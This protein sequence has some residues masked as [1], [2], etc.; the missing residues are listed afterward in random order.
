M[1]VISRRVVAS[2]VRTAS[3]TWAVITSLLAPSNGDGRKELDSIAGVV[4]SLI[5]E[6]SPANDP[7]VVWGN[8]PRVRVYCL[9]GEDAITEDGKSEDA[10]AKSPT[11]GDWAMSLPCP[12]EEL[13]W[14]SK[15]LAKHSTRI[16]ARKLG[17]AVPDDESASKSANTTTEIDHE[18]FFRP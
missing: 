16:T 12:E 4:C 8:G 9:F 1:S 13:S 5:G 14:I 6:E 18:A 3:E 17:D 2:P 7:I 15:E 11:E 10:L